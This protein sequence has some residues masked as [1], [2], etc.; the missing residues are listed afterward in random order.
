M[1]ASMVYLE[2]PNTNIEFQD[3]ASTE[4]KLRYSAGE[5]QGWRLNMVGT[6]LLKNFRKT[7]T[8]QIWSSDTI[9]V[10]SQCST[11]MVDVRSRTLQKCT[12]S[13]C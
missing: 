12:F 10:Y 1:G 4:L 7:R 8:F 9:K 11:V 3:G 2:K 6:P 5:M 13:P